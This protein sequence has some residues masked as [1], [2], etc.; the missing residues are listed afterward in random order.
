MSTFIK[1]IK[2]TYMYICGASRGNHIYIITAQTLVQTPAAKS[3]IYIYIYIYIYGAYPGAD[4]RE[5]RPNHIYI[6]IYIYI[7]GA[8]P[9]RRPLYKRSTSAALR[10]NCL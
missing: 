9:W 10:P 7:Y 8:Y 6:Y 2:E 1:D 5:N 4:L 3:H